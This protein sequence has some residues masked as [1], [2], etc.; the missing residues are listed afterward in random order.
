MLLK[1][2]GICWSEL[3]LT[4]AA[5]GSWSWMLSIEASPSAGAASSFLGASSATGG[6]S[7]RDHA[8][9][10]SRLDARAGPARMVHVS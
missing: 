5:K 4:T 6:S 9:A 10:S 8:A 2:V 1:T 7:L 3:D